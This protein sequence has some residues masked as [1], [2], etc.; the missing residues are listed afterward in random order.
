MLKLTR[1]MGTA[2]RL[3]RLMVGITLFIIG[4]VFDPFELATA[5]KITLGTIGVFAILSSVFAYCLL[6]EFTNSDTKD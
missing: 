5:L 4:P 1:N 6:Y 2:D 3:I